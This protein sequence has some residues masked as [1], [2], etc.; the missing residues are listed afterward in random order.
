MNDTLLRVGFD[1]I[2]NPENRARFMREAEL[3]RRYNDPTLSWDERHAMLPELVAS[4]GEETNVAAPFILARGSDVHLGRRVF[5]NAGVTIAAAAPVT[6]G[7]YTLIAPHVQIH[8]VTHPVDPAERQQWA[9]W[10][11]PITIGENVWIGAGAIICAGVT[12]GDHSVIGAGSV[13]TRDVPSCVLAA[14]NPCRVV[15]E[16]DPPDPATMYALRD[17]L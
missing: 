7:D 4:C 6:I 5:I 14:G 12:I 11:R 17:R 2:A 10:S 16:L 15:R 9:F 13:V 1:D 3:L 8:G